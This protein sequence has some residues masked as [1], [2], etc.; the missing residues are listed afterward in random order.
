MNTTRSQL[1]A[2]L[3]FYDAVADRF[4]EGTHDHDVTQNYAALLNALDNRDGMRILDFGCGTGRDLIWFRDHGHDVIGLDGSAAFV[5]DARNRTGC[6]VWHQDF[7]ALELPPAHFDGVFANASLLHVPMDDI[8]QVLARIF[9]SLK[10]G[11]VLFASN[12]RG[13]DEEAFDG[14]RFRSKW[15]DETWLELVPKAGFEPVDHYW[16]PSGLP[17][18][19]Q[20]WFAT[21]WRKPAD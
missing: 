10:A 18:D 3:R 5:E 6:E 1:D 14:Q 9:A 13:N 12:P 15:R 19:Q 4:W 20:P 21:V 16:R 11:G 17:R 7:L 2:T 8:L